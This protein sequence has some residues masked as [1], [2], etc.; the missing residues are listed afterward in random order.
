[1][2]VG[3]V[4][5]IAVALASVG[6]ASSVTSTIAP[7]RPAARARV[8]SVGVRVVPRPVGVMGARG[9]AELW[10]LD[11]IRPRGPRLFV[12]LVRGVP[13]EPRDV[14]FGTYTANESPEDGDVGCQVRGREPF[15][16]TLSYQFIRRSIPVA[17]FSA[18]YGQAA[19]GVRQVEL[20]GPGDR[21]TSLPLSAQRMFLVAFSPTARGAVELR[22][23]FAHRGSSSHAFSLP[24]TSREAGSWPR[25]RRRGAVFDYE[26]GENIVTKSYRQIV[27]RFG[28]PLSSFTKRNHTLC[29]YYDIVG[30]QNGWTFCF[31]GQAMV[32]AAGNQPAPPGVH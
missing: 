23:V 15:V 13:R 16:L 8:I 3:R 1:M 24:L 29:T 27:R 2:T 30:Y 6:C 9:T 21:E 17:R 5:L 22:L 19:P 26:I 14:C 4:A 25:L 7:T 20:I 28:P 31:K 18:M 32:G 10:V 12:T 11:P